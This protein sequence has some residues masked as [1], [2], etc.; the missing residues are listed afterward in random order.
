MIQVNSRA[1]VTMI[2]LIISGDRPDKYCGYDSRANINGNI[3]RGGFTVFC[4]WLWWEIQT[5]ASV[6]QI[7]NPGYFY[8]K[9][10]LAKRVSNTHNISMHEL[11]F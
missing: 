8:V 10:Y 7:D 1:T 4:Q 5:P 6:W 2:A 3:W 11:N 9:C